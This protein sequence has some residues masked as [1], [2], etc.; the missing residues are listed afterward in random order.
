LNP[1]SAH[2]GQ[3]PADRIGSRSTWT[4]VDGQGKSAHIA[5]S[6]SAADRATVDDLIAY[7][8]SL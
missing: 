8:L 5:W 2:P 3:L 4:I 6:D 7:L 1:S